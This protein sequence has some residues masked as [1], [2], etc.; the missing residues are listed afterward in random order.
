MPEY[1]DMPEII[2]WE[3]GVI[4][5]DTDACLFRTRTHVSQSFVADACT[6]LL[7]LTAFAAQ[8]AL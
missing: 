6:A 2:I 3:T 5:S 8:R 1:S 4:L 7:L